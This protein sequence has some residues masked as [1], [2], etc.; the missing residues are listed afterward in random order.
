MGLEFGELLSTRLWLRDQ[1]QEVE[2]QLVSILRPFV[3]HALETMVKDQQRTAS[4]RWF[5][6]DEIF[7]KLHENPLLPPHSR[8][9]KGLAEKALES[10]RR[11]SEVRDLHGQFGNKWTTNRE[12]V[13]VG[14]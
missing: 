4:I 7:D 10:L 3:K 1:L 5:T 11:E 14:P 12:Y 6:L 8:L 13:R 2:G 9:D